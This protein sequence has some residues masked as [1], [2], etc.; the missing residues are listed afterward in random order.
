VAASLALQSGRPVQEISVAALQE[1]L[2]IQGAVFDW[3][4]PLAGPAFFS[5]LFR[6]YDTNA[7]TRA[8]TPGH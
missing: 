3:V 6:L 4:P 5:N 8:L 2:K 7:G 1:K